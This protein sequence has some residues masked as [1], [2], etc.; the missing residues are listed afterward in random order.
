MTDRLRLIQTVDDLHY[1][2]I[3]GMM[4]RPPAKVLFSYL[5]IA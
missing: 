2:L 5:M 3:Q 1:Y 4:I